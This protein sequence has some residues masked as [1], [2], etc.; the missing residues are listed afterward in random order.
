M[1]RHEI[2]LAEYDIKNPKKS[3]W[4]IIDIDN[5]EYMNE[6]NILFKNV[7]SEFIGNS[8]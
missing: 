4:N 7:F 6:C 5:E 8:K 3:Q 1:C 2:N